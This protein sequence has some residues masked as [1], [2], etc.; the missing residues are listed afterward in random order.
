[1]AYKRAL[2]LILHDHCIWLQLCSTFSLLK[3]MVLEKALSRTL[4]IIIIAGKRKA[5]KPCVSSKN[6]LYPKVTYVI[7][8]HFMGQSKS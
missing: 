3:T 5:R 1:M 4:I 6:L 7:S 2:F 8:A